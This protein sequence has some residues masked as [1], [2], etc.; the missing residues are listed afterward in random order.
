VSDHGF[1]VVDLHYAFRRNTS[2][3]SAD[4]VHWDGIVHRAVTSLL[5]C[6]VCDAW[7]VELPASNGLSYSSVVNEALQHQ[8]VPSLLHCNTGFT[9]RSDAMQHQQVPSLLHCNSGFTFRS[10]GYNMYSNDENQNPAMLRSH[11]DYTADNFD[12]MYANF[13]NADFGHCPQQNVSQNWYT[14][15]SRRAVRQF[16]RDFPARGQPGQL[17]VTRGGKRHLQNYRLHPY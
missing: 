9:F 15:S 11:V 14:H 12:E 2:H 4:G 5:L 6:H 3:R 16:G 13:R 8:Q 7:H 17:L 10:D 1:D